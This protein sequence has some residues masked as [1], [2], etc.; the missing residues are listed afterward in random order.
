MPKGHRLMRH[1]MMS[2]I[3]KSDRTPNIWNMARP[4]GAGVE[5]LG[6]MEVENIL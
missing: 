3:V 6:N 5:G 4:D 1:T 2:A